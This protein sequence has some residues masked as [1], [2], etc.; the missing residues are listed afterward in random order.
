M[1]PNRKTPASVIAMGGMMAALAIVV[2][3]F[4]GMLG[5]GTY[6]APVLCV[7]LLQFIRNFCG[8]RIA[9]TWFFA[10]AI[11]SL[12]LCPDQEAAAVF[13]FLGYYPL[14]KERLDRFHLRLVCKLVYFNA[15]IGAMYWLLL[16]LFGL[17]ELR[18]EFSELGTVMLVVLLVL[19]NATF[20]LLDR[21]LSMEKFR[22]LGC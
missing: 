17:S 11:L 3:W 5:I 12:L 7:I 2:M 4:G 6:A 13:L 20:L 18:A 16:K 8:R 9:W 14:I 15:S 22:R 21:L 19:G 1:K 10:V